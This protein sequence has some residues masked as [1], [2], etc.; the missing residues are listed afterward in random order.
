MQYIAFDLHKRYTWARVEEPEG[1][2]VREKG[3]SAGEAPSRSSWWGG[4]LGSLYRWRQWGT[5]TGWRRR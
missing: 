1:V 4:E 5:G 3:W 2:L